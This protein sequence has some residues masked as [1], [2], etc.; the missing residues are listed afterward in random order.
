MMG[1]R[2]H[3]IR[4]N[5]PP[6]H[7]IRVPMEAMEQFVIAVFERVDMPASD[8]ARMAE[9][10]VATDLRC[11]FS[12]GTHQVARYADLMVEGKVN[13]RPR[14]EVVK[15]AP[16]SLVVDGDGGM[17]HLACARA[18][19][20]CIAKAKECGVAAA[21]TRNHHHFGA[22]GKYSRL[23]LSH[24]CIG[25]AMSSH[26]MGSM[27]THRPGANS[28]DV[29]YR[30]AATGS[31]VSIAIPSGE[32]PPFVLD[33]GGMGLHYSPELFEQVPGAFFKAMGVSAAII[34]LGGIF[35]GIYRPEFQSP[36]SPWESNQGTFVLAMDVAHFFGSVGE[37]KADMDAYIGAARAMQPFPGQDRAEM[38]GG[39]EWAWEAENRRDGI[40]VS[41]ER[42]EE[43]VEL[44]EQMGVPAPFAAYEDTRF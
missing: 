4:P 9:L 16:G 22:A 44:G 24:D 26:R 30:A 14:V 6:E 8:A 2:W 28:E 10:L 37:F 42:E 32:Q 7:G 15:E 12:H 33:M 5:S 11:V 34:S 19:E 31:P 25:V 23:A 13:P 18:M 41:A 1:K 27:R 29:I 36:A 38:P 35:A 43:L 40:P 21:T 39:R 3:R 20:E 17:G